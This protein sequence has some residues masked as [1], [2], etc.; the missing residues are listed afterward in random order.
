MRI[1]VISDTHSNIKTA[2]ALI[3]AVG[4]FDLFIHLGDHVNDFIA[5]RSKLRCR[6][7]GISGN[8]DKNFIGDDKFPTEM[9]ISTGDIKIFMTHGHTFDLNLYYQ[10]DKWESNISGLVSSARESGAKIALF[11]HTHR[12]HL[13]DRDGLLL[14]NPGDVY[15]GADWAHIGILEI[16]GKDISVKIYR[17]DKYLKRE[18]YLSWPL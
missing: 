17:F 3:D 8:E 4:D 11:G 15:F 9:T 16:D 18:L 6:A 12:P 1:A 7:I 13:E 14:M 5:L 2:S 10:K